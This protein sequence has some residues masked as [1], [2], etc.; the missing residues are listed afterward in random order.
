MGVAITTRLVA[1]HP[2]AV[3]VIVALI[4]AG[5]LLR[6][7]VAC[8]DDLGARALVGALFGAACALCIGLSELFGRRTTAVSSVI[9]AVFVFQA[10][11][12]L[13][14]VPPAL[15]V[16]AD[17]VR[18]DLLW[19]LASGLGMAVG[20]GL[21]FT[22]L[23]RSSST[24]VSP[25]VATLNAV[26]PYG[27]ALSRGA[28]ASALAIVGAVVAFVGLAVIALGS[29]EVKGL[30]HGLTWG[31][32]SGLG[33]GVGISLFVE[34]S[35]DSGAWA[36]VSQRFSAALALGLVALIMRHPLLPP[37]GAR[38]SAVQSGTFA[39]LSTVAVIL[40]LRINEPQTIVTSSMFPL[41][42]VLFGFLY[43]SDVVTRRQAF[44]IGLALTGIG[45][46]VGA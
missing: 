25:T 37:R 19:G 12:V 3:A 15:A 23:V 8:V 30:R 10:I 46:V 4:V 21:Y 2:V 26:I 6:A 32:L 35:D 40:G 20:L 14:S 17:F 31:I 34:V 43:F 7:C 45:F 36:A 39:G 41:A 18:A 38:W 44:G 33:Y 22:A 9:T 13:A 27:Y 42:S 1:T 28:E 11:A 16:E 24:V 29:G 5:G